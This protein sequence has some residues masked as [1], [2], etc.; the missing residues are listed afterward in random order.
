MT[1]PPFDLFCRVID[2]YGDAG[3]CWRL[4]HQ[5]ADMGCAVRLWIDR[6]DVLA[7][8]LPEL[9]PAGDGQRIQGVEILPWYQAERASAPRGGVVIEAFACMLPPAYEAGMAQQDCL[10]INLEYLS[11]EDWVASCHGLPSPQANGVPK[12]FYFPGF[13]S[14]T[15][16]LLRESGL[17]ARQVQAQATDRR[18][19][20]QALT[21]LAADAMPPEARCVLLFAYPD[22]PLDGLRDT[23]ARRQTPTWLLVPGT[24]PPTLRSQGNLTVATIPFVP[25]ARFDELLWCCDLN[26]VRGED[27]LTRAQW[28]G[29]PLVWQIYAQDDD[30]HRIKLEA[31]MQAAAW[32]ENIRALHR[33][34][35]GHDDDLMA[36]A[37]SAA[38]EPKP[39]ADW[40][41]CSE[42]WSE[43]L[44]RSP[45]LA[46]R[47]V[48]FC[49]K[50]LQKS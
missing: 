30:A 1:R 7:Q 42:R 18:M 3:V 8:L 5:L 44:H 9:D 33:A 35:N 27:S 36:Q 47:L 6:L 34:W 20:L 46:S 38:L 41:K 28:T 24:P 21:G 26:F 12:Y 17:Q 49:Q 23:F 13:T 29:S 50:K 22:A 2:N 31:W 14:S 45:D 4:A 16:G 15:G 40:A 32:P 10:W 37:L 19:R 39:W 25:Q 43:K 11:A 48:E